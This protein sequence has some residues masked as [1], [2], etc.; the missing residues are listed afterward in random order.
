[1]PPRNESKQRWF[2]EKNNV[3][4]PIEKDIEKFNDEISGIR[5]QRG[6]KK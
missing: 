3:F 4:N 1:M 5:E 6:Q 2:K